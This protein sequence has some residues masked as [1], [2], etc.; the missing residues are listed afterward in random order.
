MEQRVGTR[1]MLVKQLVWKGFNVPTHYVV[2]LD[3]NEYIHKWL[4]V[5]RGLF[6]KNSFY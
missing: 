6:L 2:A 4:L 5:T 3:Y 1:E